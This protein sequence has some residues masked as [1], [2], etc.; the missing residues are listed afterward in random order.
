MWGQVIL[1]S[2]DFLWRTVRATFGK[3]FALIPYAAAF[4][5]LYSVPDN[6]SPAGVSLC[7]GTDWAF[8]DN[9]QLLLRK[10]KA[11]IAA[12]ALTF[13]LQVGKDGRV[14]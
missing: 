1:F 7:M 14:N 8:I 2:C 4:P 11:W 6:H 5:S 9:I 13:I 12:I 3:I 10:K